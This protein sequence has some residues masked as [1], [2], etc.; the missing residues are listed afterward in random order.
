MW[1]VRPICCWNAAVHRI[2]KTPLPSV[3]I[4]PQGRGGLSLPC[5]PCAVAAWRA[6]GAKTI[7]GYI[8]ALLAEAYGKVGQIEK[9]LN[10]LAEA[11]ALADNTGERYY[12][13]EQHR[14]RG[15][16]LLAFTM[17]SRG[18]AEACFHQALDIARLQQAKSWE[19]GAATS[20]ARLWQQQGK[21]K[22]AY[23]LLAPVHG[24]FTAGFDTADLK[25]AKTLLQELA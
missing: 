17:E 10:V 23:D 4:R 20:L 7:A 15:E 25:E 13:A 2:T 24:W 14:L 1:R 22:E 3:P 5:R 19:L 12:E 11:L 6:T 18:E 21:E 9:G 8:L 16:L